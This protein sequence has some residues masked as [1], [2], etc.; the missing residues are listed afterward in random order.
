LTG[1]ICTLFL[2]YSP[3]AAAQSA[4]RPLFS[5]HSTLAVRIE[6]PMTTL[7][8]L[9][10][11]EEYLD[12]KFVVIDEAGSEQSFDLKLRTRG[13]FRRDKKTCEF[14]PIR[15]NFRTSQLKGSVLEHQDKLKL[16]THCETKERYEQLV[17]REYL[18]YRILQTLTDYNFGARLMKITY[19]DTERDN[20]I[21]RYGFVIED[22]DDIGERLGLEKLNLTALSYRDLDDPHANMV[23]I[24]EYLIG[25]TDFSLVRGPVENDCC[26]NAVPFSDGTIAK[27]IPY[28]FDHS[29]LVDAP[30]AKPN[31]QFNTRSVRTRV[32]RGR[33]S[34]NELLPDTLA[35][36]LSKKAE[37][38][39]LVDELTDL[40]EKNRRDVVSYLDDFFGEITDPKKIERNLVKK[41][42]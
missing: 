16:V 6:A 42:S 33:C 17:L 2:T 11:D 25:N 13:K 34:N 40:D 32:Y 26:H 12:G 39:A 30:Y 14:A 35:Y 8:K 23:I 28:D 7:M 36:F 21:S 15:L 31:P 10:P 18:T 41:C 3:L 20:P 19:V 27:S 4:A 9:R 37:I 29:G 5:D 24:Y 1:A 38:Y 22:E